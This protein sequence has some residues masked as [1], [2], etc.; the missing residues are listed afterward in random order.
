MGSRNGLVGKTVEW[1]LGDKGCSPP[2]PAPP[3]VTG[4][5]FS[6]PRI[7]TYSLQMVSSCSQL[8]SVFLKG[9]CPDYG[10]WRW[11]SRL[12]FSTHPLGPPCSGTPGKQV[13]WAIAGQLPGE[14]RN[15]L[16]DNS[17]II[18]EVSLAGNLGPVTKSLSYWMGVATPRTGWC[19]YSDLPLGP[20][21][22]GH[23]AV[24]VR[25]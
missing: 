9:F 2:P 11:G 22:S 4:P 5:G 7:L 1:K 8:I 13:G 23:V 25:E 15:F 24:C 16:R 6:K 12:N 21:P 20:A 10:A 19:V 18:R 17:F 14:L 3:T